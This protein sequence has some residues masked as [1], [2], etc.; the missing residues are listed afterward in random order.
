MLNYLGYIKKTVMKD[1]LT[2]VLT[3]YE[4]WTVL[5]NQ[6]VYYP[7]TVERLVL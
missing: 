3:H 6:Y 5:Y 1:R 2:K 7:L 4:F